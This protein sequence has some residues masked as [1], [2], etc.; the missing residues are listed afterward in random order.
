M[1]R[2]EYWPAA[3]PHGMLRSVRARRAQNRVFGGV[4][5]A[6]GAMLFLFKRSA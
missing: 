1:N 3:R 5:M 2:R 6:M 4:L